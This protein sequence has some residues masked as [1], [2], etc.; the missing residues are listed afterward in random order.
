MTT[1]GL[2]LLVI[3]KSQSIPGHWTNQRWPMSKPCKQWVATAPD[4]LY[5]S[6]DWIPFH[7]VARTQRTDI[8]P[9]TP[10]RIDTT[11]LLG[12]QAFKITKERCKSSARVTSKKQA[13]LQK[14]HTTDN[15]EELVTEAN[16]FQE[17]LQTEALVPSLCKLV[18]MYDGEN[19]CGRL[20]RNRS[21]GLTD[22]NWFG[23][24]TRCV[25]IAVLAIDIFSIL[26]CGWIS[27]LVF[28]GPIPYPWC[29]WSKWSN[30]Q[31]A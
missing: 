5:S 1:F 23:N 18:V 2:W 29:V 14:E 6:V 3:W 26:F 21:G 9:V 17:M 4:A 19:L 25:R 7:C 12:F 31:I 24:V 28:A 13:I 30:H 15:W 11:Q 16:D 8:R 27:S 22:W 20:M 10:L